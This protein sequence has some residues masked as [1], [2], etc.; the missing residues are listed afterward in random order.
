MTAATSFACV[1]FGMNPIYQQRAA[2]EVREVIGDE[3]QEITYDDL[4]KLKYVEMCLKD[5]LRLF[6]IAP[7]ILRRT[8]EDTEIGTCF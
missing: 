2:E 5:V 8:T 6:P 1:C 4:A 3:Q 7:Y